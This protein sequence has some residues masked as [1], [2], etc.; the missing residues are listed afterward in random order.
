MLTASH[1]LTLARAYGDASNLGLLQVGRLAT[2]NNRIF[3]RLAEGHGCN[4]RTAEQAMLWFVQNWPEGTPWPLAV[5]DS[6]PLPPPVRRARRA[7]LSE[8][9]AIAGTLAT[10]LMPV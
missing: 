7:R 5:P 3:V 8:A 4:I 6:R 10:L 1:L 2:G 9:V